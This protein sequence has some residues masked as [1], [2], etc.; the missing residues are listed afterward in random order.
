MQLSPPLANTVAPRMAGDGMMPMPDSNLQRTVPEFRSIFH[1]PPG[2]ASCGIAPNVT[3]VASPT[4][5]GSPCTH[6]GS[7]TYQRRLP[8]VR[9][10]AATLPLLGASVP[11]TT[12]L[13]A[14]DKPRIASGP[15]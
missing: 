1:N 7:G 3:Y 15:L 13:P 10:S 5:T 12:E 4:I 2:I 14:T 11:T 9:S 8:V 6:A